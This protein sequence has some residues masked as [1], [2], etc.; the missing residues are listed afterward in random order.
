MPDIIQIKRGHYEDLKD[1]ILADGEIAMTANRNMDGGY[2]HNVAIPEHALRIGDRESNHQIF[3]NSMITG[4]GIDYF[5]RLAGMA[6]REIPQLKTGSFTESGQTKIYNRGVLGNFPVISYIPGSAR[7]FV[8]EKARV[9]HKGLFYN[10]HNLE[11]V[12]GIDTSSQ[13]NNAGGGMMV[14]F[15]IYFDPDNNTIPSFL[16]TIS[17]NISAYVNT[18]FNTNTWNPTDTRAISVLINEGVLNPDNY[19]VVGGIIVPDTGDVG[20][21]PVN[22]ND[23]L[24]YQTCVITGGISSINSVV[25]KRFIGSYPLGK[26][27]YNENEHHD[28]FGDVGLCS[29]TDVRLLSLPSTNNYNVTLDV[30]SSYGK[31]NGLYVP[32]SSKYTTNFSIYMDGLADLVV[33]NWAIRDTSSQSYYKSIG[34]IY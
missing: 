20:N 29:E 25:L 30:E 14:L 34:E 21:Q 19:V 22:R 31:I 28:S 16:S 3:P 26:F 23:L 2:Q 7:R 8:L 9:F 11:T 27:V 24:P 33:V 17:V 12:S 18:Y 10:F 5:S 15:A 6:G 13:I 32:Q 4:M 1:H